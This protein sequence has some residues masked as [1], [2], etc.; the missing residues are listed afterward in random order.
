VWGDSLLKGVALDETR[1]RYATLENSVTAQCEELGLRVDNNARFGST[2]TKGWQRL[3]QALARGVE[4]DALLIEFG[5]NDCD[6]DWAAVAE[7]PHAPHAPHTPLEIFKRTL[8]DMLDAV[9]KKG[10]EPILMSLPPIDA[11]RYFRWITRAGLNKENILRFLG[12]VGHIYRAQEQYS[13][14]VT[15]LALERR[16]HYADVR[17]AFLAQPV[18]GDLLCADGIHPNGRGHTVMRE[19]LESS[20]RRFLP[21]RRGGAC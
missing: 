21:G 12:D 3:T 1:G 15:N 11:E 2:I 9:R 8:S 20:L 19:A 6:Y 4:C 18:L 5:G 16:C 10:I 13:V 14:A 7:N 17:G